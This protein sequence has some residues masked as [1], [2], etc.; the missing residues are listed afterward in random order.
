MKLRQSRPPQPEVNLT[1]LIDVVFILLIF[2][3]VSTTFQRESKIKIELP[4]ASAEVAEEPRDV[5]EIVIDVEG[6]YFIDQ[7]QVVNT[8]LDTLISAIGKA[9][10]TETDVPVVIRA[11]R[12][13]PYESVVRA[14]D[15][16]AQLGLVKISLATSQPA[17][18]DE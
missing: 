14:M 8:E 11:D 17:S 13:T 16:T 6:R 4:E 9:I 10:G 18:D 3:M 1:P 5:L 7:A 12:H 15:A 2:F